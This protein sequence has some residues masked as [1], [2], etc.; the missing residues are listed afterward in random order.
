[1]PRLQS[2]CKT[3]FLQPLNRQ[4]LLSVGR[5]RVLLLVAS[6]GCSLMCFGRPNRNGFTFLSNMETNTLG[7]TSLMK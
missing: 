6:W 3:C 2:S 1:M 7:A 5:M 4:R